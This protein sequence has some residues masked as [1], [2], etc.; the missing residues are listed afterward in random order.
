MSQHTLLQ[1]GPIRI[2]TDFLGFY[3]GLKSLINFHIRAT[4]L[5]E[6]LPMET[7]KECHQRTLLY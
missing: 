7:A 4:D 5:V 1:R 3:T 6:L 2:H